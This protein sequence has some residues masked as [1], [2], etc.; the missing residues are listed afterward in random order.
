MKVTVLGSGA[1]EGIPA[2]FC[3]CDS[4]NK[5]REAGGKNLRTRSQFYVEDLMIDLGDDTYCHT[6]KE[7]IA[8]TKLKYLLITHS[9]IDH[10]NPT[11]LKYRGGDY[12]TA[13]YEEY[14]NVYSPIAVK[15]IYDNLE[16]GKPSDDV[17]SKIIFTVP[18]E[19]EPFYADSY[20][21]HAL[22]A[23]HKKNEKCYIYC[24]EKDGKRVLFGNDS[25]FYPEETFDYLRDKHLDLAFLDCTYGL[26]T[27]GLDNSHM[28]F[29][30]NLQVKEKFYANKTADDRTIFVSTH[31]T[32]IC[33]SMHEEL[34]QEMDKHGFFASYDGMQLII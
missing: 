15:E 26:Q 27:G 3:N 11:I 32:H 18:V 16:R 12:A 2:L 17:E 28:D 21:I 34:C 14:L 22:L 5:V 29:S 23:N 10:Y 33:G 13:V 20:T 19:F 9:H 31:F 24:V 4:C 1:S 25:A 30:V 8:L 6:L 7:G